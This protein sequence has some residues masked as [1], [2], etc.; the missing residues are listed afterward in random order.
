MV[1]VPE[2]GFRGRTVNALGLIAAR[3]FKSDRSP[4][5][6][7]NKEAK[8]LIEKLKKEKGFAHTIYVNK[9]GDP[10][11]ISSWKTDLMVTK[12]FEEKTDEHI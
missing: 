8:A 7:I 9:N 5:M 10:V 2:S 11:L 4:Q 3:Q 12:L 1:A 6:K